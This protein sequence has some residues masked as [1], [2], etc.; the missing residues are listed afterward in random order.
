MTSPAYLSCSEGLNFIRPDPWPEVNRI[1]PGRE[2]YKYES[3]PVKLRFL[4]G[5]GVGGPGGGRDS[6]FGDRGFDFQEWRCSPRFGA[7]W[8]GRVCWLDSHGALP[9]SSRNHL[10]DI[11]EAI[12]ESQHV[13][14]P[15]RELGELGVGGAWGDTRSQHPHSRLSTCGDRRP[16]P[17]LPSPPS[18]LFLPL[19]TSLCPGG[20]SQRGRDRDG[21]G[22]GDRETERQRWR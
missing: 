19:K 14:C 12:S 20:G 17:N 22:D 15:H 11:P 18:G 21:D 10:K 13:A 9:S 4:E 6:G 5:A 8:R 7:T 16:V 1:K 2:N 3:N